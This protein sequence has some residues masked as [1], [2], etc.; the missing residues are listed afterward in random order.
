VFLNMS[1]AKYF[2]RLYLPMTH[3]EKYSILYE[4]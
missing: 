1:H 4:H 2:S 3:P